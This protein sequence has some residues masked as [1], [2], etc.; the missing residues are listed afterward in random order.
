[1]LNDILQTVN[2][3]GANIVGVNGKTDRNK[4]VM[5]HLSILI[6]NINHLK[7]AVDQIKQIKDVYTVK[8]VVQ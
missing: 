1:M 8:R 2:E 4:I 3:L 7:K 5:I 6:N